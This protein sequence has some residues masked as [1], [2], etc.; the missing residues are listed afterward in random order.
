MPL[1]ASA[2]LNCTATGPLYQPAAL[3][4][5]MA[6]ALIVGAVMSTLT[7]YVALPSLPARSA[8]LAVS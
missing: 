4:W 7:A 3:G 2:Q 5:I 8:Q 1:S 6:A